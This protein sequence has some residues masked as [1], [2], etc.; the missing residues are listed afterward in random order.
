MSAT[1]FITNT[2]LAASLQVQLTK[3]IILFYS[4]PPNGMVIYHN[5]FFHLNTQQERAFYESAGN[6]CI[7]RVATSESVQNSLT[8]P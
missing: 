2:Q 3:Q 5:Y 6:F 1:G 7:N 4:Q 8:F